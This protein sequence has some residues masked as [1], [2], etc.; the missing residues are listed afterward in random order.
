M[1]I[2]EVD[3]MFEDPM[4]IPTHRNHALSPSKV[5]KLIKETMEDV[6]RPASE[7]VEEV[8]LEN[9]DPTLPTASLPNSV[10]LAQQPNKAVT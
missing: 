2:K 9:L 1:T 8:M 5:S 10:N 4:N 7:I 6:L 3:T